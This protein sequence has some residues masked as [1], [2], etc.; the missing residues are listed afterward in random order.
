[1]IV[2]KYFNYSE[3]TNDLLD[4]Y[5]KNDL[6]NEPFLVIDNFLNISVN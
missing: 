6:N 2:F 1:M 5:P 3:F 4:D